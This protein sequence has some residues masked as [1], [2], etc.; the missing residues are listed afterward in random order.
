MFTW[1]T[2]CSVFC[3]GSFS[4]FLPNLFPKLQ[5]HPIYP[6]IEL[7][8]LCTPKGQKSVRE[9]A[10]G[11]ETKHNPPPPKVGRINI[12]N[13]YKQATSNYLEVK[14]AKVQTIRFPCSWGGCST[15][16][17]SARRAKTSSNMRL[18]SSLWASSR[19]RN[20]TVIWTL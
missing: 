14:G 3:R 20:I 2:I 10:N 15:L 5:A 7:V 13:L 9:K 17:T 16:P 4:I 11:A 6:D 19:P 18:P 12:A 1:F 8:G